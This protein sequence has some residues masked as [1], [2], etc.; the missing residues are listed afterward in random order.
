MNMENKT[1]D[2][3]NEEQKKVDE[4]VIV[5]KR[6]KQFDG[7]EYTEIHLDLES[8]SGEDI[9][10]AESQFITQNPQM[11]ATVPVKEMSKGFLAIVA[12]KAAKVPVE[13]IK[14]L[15]ASDYSKITMKVQVFLL[16]GE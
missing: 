7:K 9:E 3:Q 11:A 14:S 1:V 13:M 5:L 15:S 16:R 6:P 8:L 12:A 10:L 2:I 4:N